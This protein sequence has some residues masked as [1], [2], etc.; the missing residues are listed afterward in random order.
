MKKRFRSIIF[1][2]FLI[3][4]YLVAHELGV[5][6]IVNV[7]FI[8][9]IWQNHPVLSFLAF[10]NLF[11]LAG[12]IQI[13]GVIFLFAS[14]LTLGKL[15]GAVITYF[16]TLYGCSFLFILARKFGIHKDASKIK[17]KLLN[18][19]FN[20]LEKKPIKSLVVMRLIGQASPAL[21]LGLAFSPIKFR[22]YFFVTALIIPIPILIYCYFFDFFLSLGSL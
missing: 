18:K 5:K 14:V 15:W 8:S 22:D 1:I 10:I 12:M 21:N 17:I 7:E 6:S 13:P 3:G 19:L 20:N 2:L 4:I 11:A 16:A 9:G